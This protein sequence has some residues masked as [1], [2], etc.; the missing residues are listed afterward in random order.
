M[1]KRQGILKS[2]DTLK[3]W[4]KKDSIKAE[5]NINNGIFS[6]PNSN[7]GT[8][9]RCYNGHMDI[10]FKIYDK[11]KDGTRELINEIYNDN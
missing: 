2:I 6:L 7:G 4:I 3:E 10:T 5:Y 9:E 1:Y 11:E 8:I